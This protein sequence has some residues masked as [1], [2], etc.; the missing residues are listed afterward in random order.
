MGAQDA[1][2][3]IPPRHGDAAKGI[4]PVRSEAVVSCPGGRPPPVEPDNLMKSKTRIPGPFWVPLIPFAVLTAQADTIAYWRFEG[5]GATVP[6]DGAYA[7]DTNGRT[8]V[9]AAGIPVPD[10][11]G[12]GNRL[13]TWNDDVSG[14]VHRPATTGAP[15]LTVPQT[16]ETNGWFIE[17]SGAFPASFTWSTQTAPTG[18]NLDTWTSST[19]TIEASFYTDVLGGFRTVVGREG[20]DVKT[21]EPAHAPLY[22]QKMSNDLF[23]I[24]YVDATGVAHEAVDTTPMVAGTW[25]HF[26][27]TSDGTTLKLYK[28]TGSSGSHVEVAST[29]LTGSADPA[30]INPGNDANGHAWG[31]TVGRGRYGTSDDPTQNHGDR[32]DGGIDEVRISNV[33]LQPSEFLASFSANDGDGD[34]LPTVWE[35]EHSLDPADNGS[36]NADN[37]ASGN[38]DADAY[39]NLQEYTAGSDPRNAASIPG[40]I[41]GDGLP[42]AWEQEHFLG[43]TQ[44]ALGDPDNDYTPNDEEYAAGTDPTARLDFPETEE[45]A[46]GMPDAWE[47]AFLSETGRDGT[48]D[49]DEDGVSDLQE[50]LDD[51]NPANPESALNPTGDADGDGLDDRWELTHFSSV[52]DEGAGDDFDSDGSTNLQEYQANSN[53]ALASSTHTDV[54]GDGLADVIRFM[55]FKTAGATGTITDVDAEPTG[56]VRLANTGTNPAYLPNDP[57]I[58]LD[59]TGTGTFTFR[60]ETT[61]FNGQSFMSNQAALGI[62]LSSLGF[63]G[64]Q[65]F[66]VRVKFINTPAMGG[67]DQIGIFAGASSTQLVRGGRIGTKG[68]LGVNTNGNNDSDAVFPGDQDSLAAGKP[69]TVEL[70]RTGGVWAL[71]VHG[72]N[73]TPG[74]Q[75][76]FLDSLGDLTVGFYGS[77]LFTGNAHKFPVVESLTVVRMGGTNPDGDGD[78]MDDDWEI[79][80][81]GGTGQGGNDDADQDGAS[82]LAE[83]AF[84]GDPQNGADRGGVTTALADT[85]ANGQSELTLTVPVRS[86]ATFASGPN[87]VQT[88]T[89]GGVVYVIR[90]SL[91]LL[92][93]TSEVARVGSTVSGDPDYE[94]HT[95]RL[96]ASEG[97]SG[98]GFLQAVAEAVE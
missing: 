36:V 25:Y 49:L 29:T 85:N 78:G 54:N 84:N 64:N 12:N 48:G 57:N 69:M 42:D 61:D 60:T 10:L 23:R 76:A 16:G 32:W 18:V 94:L 70:S 47:I 91:D 66:T 77:D 51:T 30:L 21:G 1:N 81:L 52:T 65:D 6:T 40:D 86:G 82:N 71:S 15:F 26:A 31:W 14:H 5:E 20:N 37:G 35:I 53:P 41:D 56:L 97:L 80:K 63:T 33:A 98:R 89:V 11:S 8:A 68:T 73:L 92:G 95:F 59:T 72:V 88:A 22:F 90:G 7:Q 2:L 62:Q 34:G 75:P 83:F 55:D 46:D 43:L 4:W 24:A 50:F 93:F 44:G 13:V 19:W 79:A 87:G 45:P 28:K 27:A 38:P 3:R 9:Q 74:V 58:N 67:A 39:T 17:N 96:T